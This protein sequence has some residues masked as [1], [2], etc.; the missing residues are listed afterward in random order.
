MLTIKKAAA[1]TGVPEHT[2]RAWERRYGLFAPT[3]SASG[4]R[5]YDEASLARI[6]AMN[7]LVLDGVP[8]REASAVVLGRAGAATPDF[9]WASGSDPDGR[10][11][12][13]AAALDAA[14]IARVL[15][16]QFA[17]ADFESVVDGWLMPA[18]SVVGHAWASGRVSVAGEHLVAH[19]VLRRLATAYEAAGRGTGQPVVIGNPPGVHHELGLMAFAVAARRA[20]LATLYLG[21]DVPLEAWGDAV[22]T[23][24]ARAVVTSAHQRRDASRATQVAQQVAADAPGLPVWVGG[25]YQ[26]LVPAPARPLGHRIG[27]AARLLAETLAPSAPE[28]LA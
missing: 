7:A 22:R 24:D 14:G 20:G 21:A 17:R 15:D 18:L 1:A 25:R 11:V 10:L 12:E 28:S 9:A 6:R 8:P 23:A 3:R 16:D 4:Y 19:S 5:V 26:H 27:D 2:L 13:A